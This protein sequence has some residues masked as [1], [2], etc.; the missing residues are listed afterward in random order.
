M[1][2]TELRSRHFLCVCDGSFIISDFREAFSG[3]FDGVPLRGYDIICYDG[4]RR[5]HKHRMVP[6][7]SSVWESAV[8]T[9]LD[10]IL[11]EE[12]VDVDA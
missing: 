6:V 4:H 1:E 8:L 11:L 10:E 3:Q 12:G 7:S 5:F 9:N 2:T